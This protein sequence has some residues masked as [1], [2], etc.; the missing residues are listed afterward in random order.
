M[1]KTD[2][3]IVICLLFCFGCEKKNTRFLSDL[4]VFCVAFFFALHFIDKKFGTSVFVLMQEKILVS[5]FVRMLVLVLDLLSV[6]LAFFGRC[7]A[8]VALLF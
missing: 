4:F 8:V 1:E 2:F 7:S 5:V 3:P 6:F